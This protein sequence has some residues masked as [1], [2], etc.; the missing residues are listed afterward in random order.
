MF[1]P[2]WVAAWASQRSRNG[3][4]AK[5]APGPVP[6]G[7]SAGT[8]VTTRHRGAARG[9]ARRSSITGRSHV[10][11]RRPM[12]A[13][14]RSTSHS[15]PPHG[16]RR[17]SRTTSPRRSSSTGRSVIFEP[18]VSK[19]RAAVD[20]Y[21]RPP[22]R[23]Q[24]ESVDGRDRQERARIRRR[25]LGDQAAVPRQRAGQS[26]RTAESEDLERVGQRR[27][28]DRQ[29]AGWTRDDRPRDHTDVLDGNR[30]RAR[31]VELV[32]DVL[33]ALA[34]DRAAHGD[35]HSGARHRLETRPR[36]DAREI[37]P[38]VVDRSLAAR[39]SPRQVGELLIEL[40]YLTAEL[41][42]VGVE[43]ADEDREVLGGQPAEGGRRALRLELHDDENPE[44]DRDRGDG[45]LVTPVVH[46]DR[47]RWRAR[48][49]RRGRDGSSEAERDGSGERRD[50]DALWRVERDADA[51]R[52]G[53]RAEELREPPRG[54]YAVVKILRP[55]RRDLVRPRDERRVDQDRPAD[56]DDR[57]GRR[58]SLAVDR[59][60]LRAG[61][62]QLFDDGADVL[63]GDEVVARVSARRD[64]LRRV[65]ELE[66]D[67]GARQGNETGGNPRLLEL[68]VELSDERRRTLAPELRGL[69][70]RPQV[71]N[72]RLQAVL[73]PLEPGDGLDER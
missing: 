31:V 57:A 60:R 40:G 24:I 5:T 51:V 11:H 69:D 8:A 32:D 42:V 66:H 45:H 16:C 28:L 20:G 18:S 1:P 62:P 61:E 37:A 13:P 15:V 2:I 71:E 38:D 14:S 59:H 68:V 52:L 12:S 17:F 4:F 44:Q 22:G 54:R 64:P 35:R 25:Q 58:Q 21:E 7:A 43:V 19:P 3:R 56:V 50:I 6:P 46:G 47:S 73:L 49:R 41:L 29:P 39:L 63:G 23:R 48:R 53:P 34:R 36:A 9:R 33:D 30:L 55:D 65:V 27:V 72:P 26:L 67:A 70:L 10:V